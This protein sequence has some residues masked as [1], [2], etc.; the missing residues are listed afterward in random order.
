M[1]QQIS[2][3]KRVRVHHFAEWQGRQRSLLG[4][5]LIRYLA[6]RNLKLKNR[7]III[8]S[9]RYG[10]PHVKNNRDFQFNISHSGDWVAGVVDTRPVGIDIQEKRPCNFDIVKRFFSKS[11]TE[12]F[13]KLNEPEKR[14]YFYDLWTLKE[15][16]I[17]KTGKGFSMLLNSFTLRKKRKNYHLISSTIAEKGFFKI[18]DVFPKY[19]IAVCACN[20][21][22]PKQIKLLDLKDL[23][24]HPFLKK[25][26][27]PD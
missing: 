6:C 12:D 1:L 20:K 9:D 13:S 3:A 10:K 21:L 5:I 25:A 24:N 23:F 22:F 26:T 27:S 14:D 19:K 7:D 18:Y 8:E 2:K 17:K 16:Y 11:E 15:S 4:E